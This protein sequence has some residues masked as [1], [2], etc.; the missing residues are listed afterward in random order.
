MACPRVVVEADETALARRAADHLVAAARRTRDRF[1]LA[2]SGGATPRRLYS[3][4]AGEAFAPQVP[5]PR[6]EVFFADERCVPPDHPDSNFGAAW[7]LL[8]SRVDVPPSHLHRLS[9]E[10]EDLP[11]A[12]GEYETELRRVCSGGELG[13]DLVLL[14]IGEDGHTAS[15][16]P[17]TKALAETERW[18]AANRVPQLNQWRL[19][20]TRPAL[21][22]AGGLLFLVSGEAKAEVVRRVLSGDPALPAAVVAGEAR[23][24]VF[25]LD[26]SAASAWRRADGI[27]E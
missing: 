2:L 8:L 24:A 11:A 14:G 20:L 27:P 10:T 15:L 19:T 6:V 7:E 17:G 23:S 18:V 13:L 21:A 1:R 5:W 9:G 12:A 16:F 4:L 22:A 25:M 26:E 3:L